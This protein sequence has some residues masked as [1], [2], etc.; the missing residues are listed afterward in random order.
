MDLMAPDKHPN[1][2]GY[3]LI[4]SRVARFVAKEK[5]APVTEAQVDSALKELGF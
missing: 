1:E 5:L 2:K 4:A 3:A